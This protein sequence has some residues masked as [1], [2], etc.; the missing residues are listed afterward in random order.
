MKRLLPFLLFTLL[1]SVSCKKLNKLT[2][3]NIEYDETFVIPSSTGIGLPV[4]FLTPEIPSNSESQFAVNDTRK[5]LIE[6]IML[7]ELTLTVNSPSSGNFNFLKSVRIFIKAEGLDEL[8][9]AWRENMED[10]DAKS[11]A[12][13]VT[14]DDLQAYIKMDNFSVRVE[15]VTDQVLSPDHEIK[16]H[17]VY[18]VDA[19][20]IK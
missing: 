2:Q 10:T 9:V 19:K 4:S 15:T 1:F 13:N 18:F 16:M 3:F 17:S 20:L 12:L 7:T 11:I 6:S 5:D 14:C 8:K